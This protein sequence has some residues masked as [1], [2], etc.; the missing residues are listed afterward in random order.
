MFLAVDIFMALPLLY[1]M[2]KKIAFEYFFKYNQIGV[3]G[4]ALTIMGAVLTIKENYSEF[5]LA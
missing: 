4:A 3:V 5:V 2:I 1:I